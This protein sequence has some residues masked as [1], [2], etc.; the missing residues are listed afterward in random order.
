MV[1]FA[2]DLASVPI[3]LGCRAL[4]GFKHKLCITKLRYVYIY[5]SFEET[6][7]Q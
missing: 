5:G 7:S 2:L 3:V 4:V 1:F 6:K